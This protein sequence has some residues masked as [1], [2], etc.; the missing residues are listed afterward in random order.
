MSN[1]DDMR[2]CAPVGSP[3][4]TPLTHP[5]ARPSRAGGASRPC[6]LRAV[7]DPD[8]TASPPR[9]RVLQ[10]LALA[11]LVIAAF[12]AGMLAERLRFDLERREMLRR[13]DH[14]L[15]EHRQEIMRSEQHSKQARP[16]PG[17]R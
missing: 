1:L 5:T 12:L 7:T 2:G 15:H 10:A 8:G 4:I 3:T 9:R 17:A 14:A 13:Y 11:A 6:I 16:D